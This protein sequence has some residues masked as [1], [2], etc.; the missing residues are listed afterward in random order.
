MGGGCLCRCLTEA[1]HWLRCHLD[2]VMPP[3]VELGQHHRLPVGDH[4]LTVVQVK[5]QLAENIVPALERHLV[6]I[7]DAGAEC[8]KLVR[9]KV[10]GRTVLKPLLPKL[11]D[12]SMKA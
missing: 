12:M 8:R 7:E 5:R 4:A 10:T 2:H 11:G 3:V 1:S 6:L 9:N